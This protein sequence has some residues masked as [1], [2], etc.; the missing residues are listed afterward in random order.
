MLLRLKYFSRSP[1]TEKTGGDDNAVV[2][3]YGRDS[4]PVSGSLYENSLIGCFDADDVQAT[5]ILLD[6]LYNRAV[7][8]AKK[9]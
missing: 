6:F 5:K 1:D 2:G 7:L 4:S 3:F 9:K 8:S